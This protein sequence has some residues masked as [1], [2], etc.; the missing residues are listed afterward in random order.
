MDRNNRSPP[1]R[2]LQKV[3]APLYA[4]HYEANFA[5]RSNQVRT[6]GAREPRHAAMVMR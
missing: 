4:H 5:E 6:R 1:I 2:V 3:V